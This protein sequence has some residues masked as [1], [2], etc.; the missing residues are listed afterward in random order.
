M[1]IYKNKLL[2]VKEQN[3]KY[4]ENISC[5]TK[6]VD[7]IRNIIKIQNEPEEV[8]TLIG[9]DAKNNILGFSE[10]SRGTLSS[11]LTTGREIFK[12]AILMNCSKILLTHNHPSGDAT[13]SA[14]DVKIT[15]NIKE[16]SNLFDIQVID[17]IIIGDK[18]DYSI[19]YN[20]IIGGNK[21]DRS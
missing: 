13:P 6:A 16:I 5:T 3:F 11:S 19:I 4:N 17:H 14:C 10:V 9:L 2:M 1:E 20:S 15:E 8:F 18:E 7:F 12:R 21:N